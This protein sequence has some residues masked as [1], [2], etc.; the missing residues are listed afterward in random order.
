M[1]ATGW[2]N[3]GEGL[4]LLSGG[5]KGDV[6]VSLI[7]GNMPLVEQCVAFYEEHF[8]DRYFLELIRT[9]RQDEEAYLHAA[10]ALAEARGLPVVATNDVRFLDTSDFDA[11]EI[12]VAIHDGFTLD[13]PKRPRNY[14]PQQYMRSEEEMCELFADIPEALENSVE[15]AKRCNVTVRLGEYF[16]PQFPT[17]DMTTEDFTVMKSKRVWKSGWNFSSRI[18]P[19]V[20]KSA[21][22]MTSVWILNSGDQPDGVPGLLPDRYGVYPVVEG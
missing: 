8:P 4:I 10:V 22:S 2:W 16:L 9:G 1:T 3:T 21:R 20:L 6:G 13:D 15:I 19:S 17:G 14:S 12:R 18:L 11:H 7:R 5:R